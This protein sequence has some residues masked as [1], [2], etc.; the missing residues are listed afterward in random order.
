MVTDSAFVLGHNNLLTKLADQEDRTEQ[1]REQQQ[2]QLR[3]INILFD[4]KAQ[5]YQFIDFNGLY[6]LLSSIAEREKAKINDKENK[7]IFSRY[8]K[9]K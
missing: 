4:D 2:E 1:L 6:S 3:K 9:K 8:R 5:D 7:S